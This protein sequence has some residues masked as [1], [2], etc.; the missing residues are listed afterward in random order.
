MADKFNEFAN[1]YNVKN[2]QVNRDRRS[3]DYYNRSVDYFSDRDEIVDIEM[4]RRSFEH[5][6]DTDCEFDKMYQDQ[7]EEAYMRRMHPA[8][9]EAYSKYK[10]LLELYK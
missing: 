5:L 9:N 6:V 3:F 4:P 7:R 8:I 2:I 10:M 1:R